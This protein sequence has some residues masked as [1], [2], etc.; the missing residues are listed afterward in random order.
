MIFFID[1]IGTANIIFVKKKNIYIYVRARARVC[2]KKL[3][4]M[5]QRASDEANECKL[6]S[7]FHFYAN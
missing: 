2:V 5:Y 3:E 6:K 7:A 1:G 4:G